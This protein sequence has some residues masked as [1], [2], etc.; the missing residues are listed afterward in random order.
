MVFV[1][2]GIAAK[3]PN[4]EANW[5]FDAEGNI[6]AACELRH[7]AA[8]HRSLLKQA[9]FSNTHPEVGKSRQSEARDE[10]SCK[11]EINESQEIFGG[12]ALCG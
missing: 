11:E 9:N 2:S 4:S 5:I 6:G 12:Q 10:N 7:I 1:P 8:H 3:N